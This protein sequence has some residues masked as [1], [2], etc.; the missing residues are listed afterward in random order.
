MPRAVLLLHRKRIY[1]DGGVLELKLWTVPSEVPGSERRLRYS[2]YY[3]E[4]GYRLVGYDNERGK[5]DHRHYAEQ[6][7]PYS[8]S[9]VRRLVVDILNDV[10]RIRGGSS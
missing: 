3:G 2:L 5:G 10:R 4:R 7:E 1:D 6:E 9:G 8:F